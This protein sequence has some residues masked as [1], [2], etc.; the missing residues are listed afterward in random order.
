MMCRASSDLA[1]RT[2][3]TARFRVQSFGFRASGSRSL[4]LRF[5]FRVQSFGF[6]ASG[7]RSLG[8]NSQPSTPS[9]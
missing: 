7:A 6:R 2:R 8:L 4:G 1:F 5:K 9:D 3:L